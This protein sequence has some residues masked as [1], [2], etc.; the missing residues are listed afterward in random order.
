MAKA[1]KILMQFSAAMKDK[2]KDR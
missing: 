2:L 1:K